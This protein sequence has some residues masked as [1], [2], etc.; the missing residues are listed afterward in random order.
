VLEW[1]SVTCCWQ[2][3]GTVEE[4]ALKG[5]KSDVLDVLRNS[6]DTLTLT[7]LASM[8]D[9]DKGNLLHILRDLVTAGYVE[10]CAKQGREVPYRL[11]EGAL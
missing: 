11:R 7:E 4:A 10:R 6:G 3:I 8:T 1:D 2:L 9:I 5:R